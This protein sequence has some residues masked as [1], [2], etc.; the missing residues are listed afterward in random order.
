MI[1][2]RAFYNRY[3]KFPRADKEPPR[4]RNDPDYFPFFEGYLGAVDGTHIESFVASED[5]PRLTLPGSKGGISQSTFDQADQCRLVFLR[6]SR[7]LP[8]A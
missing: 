3:V 4:I 8:V 2:S 1:V 7:I 5:I 6:P